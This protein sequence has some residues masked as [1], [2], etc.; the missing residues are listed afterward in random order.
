MAA[1][2]WANS[3]AP[4]RGRTAP[5]GE[6]QLWPQSLKTAVG[7]LLNSGYPMYIAWG[8]HFT[9][10]YNDAYRPILGSTKHPQALGAATADTFSEIW[11]YIGPMFRSVL[12]SGEASTFVDQLLPLNRHGYTEECYFVFSYSPILTENGEVGGVF[13]TVLETS[14]RVIR[15][16]RQRVLRELAG[17]PAQG[18]RGD[19]LS[20][21]ASVLATAS[22]DLPLLRLYALIDERMT[23]AGATGGLDTAS[24]ELV[25]PRVFVLPVESAGLIELSNA[26][27]CTP[28]PEPVTRAFLLPIAVPGQASLAGLILCG[29]SPRL[30]W[31]EPYEDFLRAVAAAIGRLI[32]EAEAFEHE[33]QRA[34]GLAAIDAAKTAF[35]SNVS[36]EF[37]TPLTLTLGPLEEILRRQATGLST[38]NRG[39]IETAHRNGLRLLKLVNTLLDFSRIEAGR[40]LGTYRATDLARYTEELASNFRAAM[41]RAGLRYRVETPSLGEPVYVD[42]EM[43]EK[44]VLNLLSNAFKFTFEGEVSVALHRSADDKAAELVVRDTG[45]GIPANELPRLFERFHRVEGARGRS[46]EGSGIGLALISRTGRPARGPGSRRQYVGTRDDLHRHHSVRHR[47]SA[48]RPYWR[49][50]H[51]EVDRLARSRLRRGGAAVAAWIGGAGDDKE[52]R[53]QRSLGRRSRSRRIANPSR[54]RQCRHAGVFGSA[55]TRSR[56]LGRARP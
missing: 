21:A 46:F 40:V 12:S 30:A 53:G 55:T 15:E 54:G 9:Q 18:T 35:F 43:W 32:A 56:V 38:T 3:Y 51:R 13:V 42:S 22:E 52:Q 44:I 16:R 11:N 19:I 39:L 8:P 45:T 49:R 47:A 17:I 25:P 20:L 23:L 36:H 31:E 34:E 27:T 10:I 37:R 14:D 24:P 48:S 6:P 41:E 7:I 29:L 5:L 26:I 2:R 4:S 1:A 28:W 50:V 33:R